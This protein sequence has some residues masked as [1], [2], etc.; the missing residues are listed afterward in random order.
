MYARKK[1]F[2]DV[3]FLVNP[4]S[5]KK[6]LT[7]KT[8]HPRKV[9]KFIMRWVNKS[10]SI[11]ITKL[12]SLTFASTLGLVAPHFKERYGVLY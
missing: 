11:S 2:V 3:G 6:H 12:I 4:I 7:S 9:H 10:N 1:V 8:L 5:P